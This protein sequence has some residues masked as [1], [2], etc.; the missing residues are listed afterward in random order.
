MTKMQRLLRECFSYNESTGFLTRIKTIDSCRIWKAGSIVGTK[1]KD[2]YI[3]TH[4]S[5][6]PWK[7]HHLVW[8]YH[9]G[10]KPIMLDHIN[11]IKGD[12]RIENLR[13]AT[14]RINSFNS[15][16]PSNNISGHKGVSWNKRLQKWHAYIGGKKSREHIGFYENR[17]EAINAR[18]AKEKEMGI[19]E[20][21][22]LC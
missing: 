9:F 7:V 3:V 14:K 12:N 5:G 4:F 18:F 22:G 20:I 16:I 2:G 10:Y 11:R 17:E 8:I 13:E 21:S 15:G 6:R 19:H 1:D